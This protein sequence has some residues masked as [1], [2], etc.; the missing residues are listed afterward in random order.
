[1]ITFNTSLAVLASSQH[2]TLVIVSVLSEVSGELPQ[3]ELTNLK[4]L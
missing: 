4:V 3:V 1:M 2:V